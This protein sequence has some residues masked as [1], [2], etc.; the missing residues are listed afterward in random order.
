M[1]S[2]SSLAPVRFVLTCPEEGAPELWVR[3][4]ELREGLSELYCLIIEAAGAA[5]AE[6]GGLLG[7]SWTLALEREE[8]GRRVHGVVT[9][10]ERLAPV[11]GRA[12]VRMTLHPALWL[13][14]HTVNTRFWQGLRAPE[15]ALEVLRGPLAAQGRELRLEVDLE[16]HP[17]REYCVQYRESDLDFALRLLQEDGIALVFDHEGERE[18]AVLRATMTEAPGLAASVRVVARGAGAAAE[19]SL[20]SLVATHEWTAGAVVHRAWDFREPEGRPWTHE[21]R[22]AGGGAEVYVHEEG[23]VRGDDGERQ[24]TLALEAVRGRSER[25]VG[26]GDVVELAPGRGLEV[27]E[28]G[29][30]RIVEATHRGEAPEVL[31][32]GAAGERYVN[33]FVAVRAEVPY[34]AAARARPRVFGPLTAIVVGPP[35]EEIH[36]DEFGRVKVRFHWDRNSPP[37]DSASCWIRV[38]QVWAGAGFGAQHVPRVGMEVVVD[39]LDGDPDRPLVTG[40]VYNATNR[41]PYPLPDEKARSGVRSD[42]TPGGGGHNE[43][44]F[45]DSKGKERVRLHAQRDLQEVVRNRHE[46]RVYGDQ[47]VEVRGDQAVTV[48]KARRVEVREGDD[49][50]V[51]ATGSRSARVRGADEL[52]VE[53]GDWRCSVDRG[54]LAMTAETAV[55]LTARQAWL[56]LQ[57]R[58]T[59]TLE[60]T[61]AGVGVKGQ[62]T[63]AVVSA[64]GGLNL[65]GEQ[66]VTL[67]STA[68]EVRVLALRDVTVAA[69]ASTQVKAADKVEL[70]AAEVRV[71]ADSE[72]SLSVGSSAIILRHGEVEI[73]GAK[74]VSA[75]TGLQE[76]TGGLVKIN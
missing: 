11:G 48:H 74:I 69:D 1:G 50:L 51:V 10:V 42:S 30:L 67:R 31:L 5:G 41:P 4:F 28:V 66:E 34:Q 39:F 12:R 15:I 43:L 65:Q 14:G 56:S 76:I 25:L 13:L 53:E 61:E 54:T 75:A 9:R 6:V 40:C 21:R 33:E 3:R 52:R 71:V 18:V 72:I 45:D 36:T 70:L 59:A 38:A 24:A 20:D 60:S 22:A 64:R 8:G 35:G 27:A 58:R 63:V 44:S 46:Q 62:E 23:G 29:R 57:A 7:S 55:E 49:E 47:S 68:G 37:D 2:S 26:R 17:I 73:R 32:E 16:D 19:Q